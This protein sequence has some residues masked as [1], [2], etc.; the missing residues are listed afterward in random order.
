MFECYWPRT[1]NNGSLDEFAHTGDP[2][3][4]TE[5]LRMIHRYV[6]PTSL[7]RLSLHII[8]V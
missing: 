6:E 2:I 4:T 1:C 7:C 3:G 8:A 5:V